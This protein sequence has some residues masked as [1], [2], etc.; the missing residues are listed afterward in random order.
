MGIAYFNQWVKSIKFYRHLRFSLDLPTG[1]SGRSPMEV[2]RRKKEEG[3]KA[4]WEEE[5]NHG[6]GGN[7]LKS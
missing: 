7:Y 5:A 4:D 2:G 1:G 3:R 6:K